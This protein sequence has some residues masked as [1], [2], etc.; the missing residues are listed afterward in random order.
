LTTSVFFTVRRW[1]F[2]SSFKL[3]LLSTIDK[4]QN[5]HL[6]NILI[7]HK[8][9]LEH[10]KTKAKPTQIQEYLSLS[11]PSVETIHEQDG[12]SVYDIEITTNRPDSLSVRGV[13]RE[14]AVILERYKIP[15]ELKPLELKVPEE[16]ETEKLPLPQINNDASLCQRIMCVALS[17]VRSKP[18]P[19]W[20]AQR[21]EQAGFQTHHSIIDITNYVTH[22]IGHPCHAFDY[23][24]IMELGGVINVEEAKPEKPFT[25]LDG[26][27]R[28]TVGGEIV[29]T[30]EIGTIIDLPAII[31]TA[32]SS[33]DENTK[34]VLFWLEDLDQKKVRQASMAHAIRTVAAQLNE[35][36]L[37]PYLGEDTLKRGIQLYREITGA[38]MASKIFDE[39]IEPP[40]PSPIKIEYAQIKRY[41][42]LELKVDLIKQ[43]MTNLGCE[44][45]MSAKTK[46]GQDT[47]FTITPPSYR[48]DLSIQADVIEE[49][50][51][52]YGYQNIPSE[53]MT[54]P[55][56]VNPPQDIDF[57]LER[58]AKQFLANI[59][60]Q[61]IYS[62]SIVSE[63]L[64]SQ[65]D[66]QQDEHLKLANPLLVE[67]TYLRRSLIPS[68]Q[69]AV[70]QNPQI[71]QLSVFELAAVYHPQKGDLPLEE[72]RL[73]MVSAK[74]YRKAR[75]D[76]E[77]LL[78]RFYI[79]KVTIKPV[80]QEKNGSKSQ[81]AAQKRYLQRGLIIIEQDGQ[82]HQIGDVYDLEGNRVGFEIELQKL[83]KVAKKHPEYQPIPATSPIIEDLTFTLSLGTRVG[84]VMQAI[85]ESDE[86]IKQVELKDS[87]QQNY[88]FNLAYQ[89]PTDNLSSEDLLPIRQKVVET[90]EK[91]FQAKLVGEI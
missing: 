82:E 66:Y 54:G 62:L 59:G 2:C 7:P 26:E 81:S 63:E 72:M 10:L 17:N 69:Q 23:D 18:T 3:N 29:F 36:Q 27:E 9:L 52:I 65:S 40:S 77:A 41:L 31:G 46:K 56:P 70:D 25:T 16:P 91:K 47:V 11:G 1:S 30:N 35:K 68:L 24:K 44:V 80:D 49:I 12:D 19:K 15:S 58:L 87:Y 13:A 38:K 14:A 45:S 50:A 76:L 4:N 51:R 61:E 86:L 21:L 32:N 89:H 20:M 55:L 64:V 73:G 79:K 37:D 6:M 57:N 84:E 75:G 85:R 90:V 48:R 28:E 5:N 8:W 33:V 60:W 78:K 67:N 43:I 71:K 83:T 42:G 22:E 39:F 88:T 53:L 34:N 74:S